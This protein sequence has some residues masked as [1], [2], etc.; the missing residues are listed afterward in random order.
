MN[1]VFRMAKEFIY[2]NARPLELARWQ[3]HF[4]NGSK[5]SVLY[6]LSFYQN[7]DG[8]FGHALE[9]DAWNPNSSP[10]QT[11]YATEILRE[12]DFTDSS[13]PIIM[14]ILNYLESGKDFNGNFWFNI[15]KSNDDYPHAPWWNTKTGSNAH[16]DY[17]PTACL[18]G[19]IIK[20]ADKNS[21]LYALGCRLAKEAV[22]TYM[23]QGFL[24][25]MATVLCYIRLMQYIEEAGLS[26]IFDINTLKAKL[27]KQVEYSIT[28]NTAEWKTSYICK[29]SQFFNSKN[30][31][32]YANNKEI[33]DYECDFIAKTQLEDGSWNIT[34]KWTAY[35]EE[36][37]V[38]KNWWKSDMIIR[39]L[40]YLRG[41]NRI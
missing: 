10:V 32:F 12:I 27:V 23:N 2:R 26:G 35:P 16:D 39:N 18:A 21:K 29:P 14:G 24:G 38:S 17:N 1:N 15:I 8:G 19:F 6:S 22:N 7:E 33:A 30:S 5:E 40:L 4:E 41:F 9:P 28:W 37:A 11:W 20:Y 25:N 31:I 34:W 3:Y 36:W 13:H